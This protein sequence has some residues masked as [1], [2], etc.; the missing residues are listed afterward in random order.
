MLKDKIKQF[1]TKGDQGD[2]KKKIENLAVFLVLLVITLIVINLIWKSDDKEKNES[3]ADPNKKLATI[4]NEDLAA[5]NVNMQDTLSS[6]L[7]EI[8]GKI[9]GVGKV[10]V[11]VTYYQTSQTVPMYNE[12]TSQK[13]TDETDNNGGTRKVVE[14]DVKREIIYEET[15]NG[16]APITQSIVSPK[17]EGA[18]IT[19]QGASNTSIK[20]NIIQ[21]VEA[22]TGVS[23]H[24]I[25]VFSMVE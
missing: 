21:A 6:Q 5:H 13:D 18:I 19:A 1:L 9:E 25:Q 4:E 15:D 10:K 7:E 8:L 14:T 24:K 17:V 20:A 2:S 12:D 11:L 22:V 3:T 16:K 23:S